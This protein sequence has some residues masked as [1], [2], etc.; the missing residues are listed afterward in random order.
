MR[1]TVTVNG[2]GFDVGGGDVLG[3]GVV[4]RVGDRTFVDV[5]LGVSVA[6]V[7]R[8]D[9]DHTTPLVSREVG[10]KTRASVSPWEPG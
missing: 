7:L 5:I 2:L 4:C 9:R 10:P 3:L 8:G 6:T 1:I